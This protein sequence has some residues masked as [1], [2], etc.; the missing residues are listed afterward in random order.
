MMCYRDMTFCSFLECTRISCVRRL[1]DDVKVRAKSWWN[2]KE[3]AP[4]AQ[5]TDKPDC[6]RKP[7]Q[8]KY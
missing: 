3:G 4:I 8:V 6:F 2:G 5:Y 1:T 7:E